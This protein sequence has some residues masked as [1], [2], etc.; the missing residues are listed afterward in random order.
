MATKPIHHN[1]DSLKPKKKKERE[2]RQAVDWEK[3]FV[4]HIFNKGLVSR[5]CKEFSN[6]TENIP[7]NP[8]KKQTR[9][10]ETFHQREYI[11]YTDANKLVKKCSLSLAI[12][13]M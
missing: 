12:R 3:I 7:N 9:H 6:S 5:L 11:G 4:S 2:K 13:K 1:E 10:E 8:I